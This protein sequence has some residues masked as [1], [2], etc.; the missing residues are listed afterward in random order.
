MRLTEAGVVFTPTDL[1]NFLACRR[2]TA[3]DLQLTK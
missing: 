2:K 1:S 3:L